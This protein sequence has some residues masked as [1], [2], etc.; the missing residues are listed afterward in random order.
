MTKI[1]ED[2]AAMDLKTVLTEIALDD[3]QRNEI[4]LYK[5]T[6]L[7]NLRIRR[8][9]LQEQQTQLG[10]AALAEKTVK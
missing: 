10:L 3:G 5:K 4:L 1:P 9:Q 2:I 7:A 6:Q 8:R